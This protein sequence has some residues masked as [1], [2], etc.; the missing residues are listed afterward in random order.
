MFEASDKMPKFSGAAWV[1]RNDSGNFFGNSKNSKIWIEYNQ[2][3]VYTDY[4][5]VR[6]NETSVTLED[7]SASWLQV[8]LAKDTGFVLYTDSK[9]G[10]K[11][12]RSGSWIKAPL[13]P[14]SQNKSF[15]FIL[16]FLSDDSKESN[17]CIRQVE[18]FEDKVKWVYDGRDKHFYVKNETTK[19]WDEFNVNKWTYGLELQ[20]YE[21]ESVILFNRKGKSYIELGNKQ[22]KLGLG[23]IESLDNPKFV[24]KGG[25]EMDDSDSSIVDRCN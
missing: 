6:M 11:G 2:N 13:F 19:R 3:R 7:R 8:V 20:T 12:K 23:P 10:K 5:L 15:L 1:W 4:R 24:F 9:T 14:K 18:T 21:G 16:F 25:W 22:V 17:F